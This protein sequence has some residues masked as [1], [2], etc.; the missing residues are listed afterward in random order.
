MQLGRCPVC[1]SRISIDALIQDESGRHLLA[2]LAKLDTTS[3]ATLI[4]YLGLFR[5]ASRDLSND[6][7]LRL[8]QD[9]Q[10]MPENKTH[11]NMAM[12]ETVN[13]MRVKQDQK[14][15]KPL[16]NH[17][18]FKALLKD[19]KN[20]PGQHQITVPKAQATPV[21]VKQETRTK[22]S[23]EQATECLNNIRTKLKQTEK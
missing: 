12:A 6:R 14:C 18:Y 23:K 8:A 13:A 5:S 11:K 10:E 15:F 2:L 1:H 19:I 16:K 22:I 7:A 17:G 21:A 3:A 9:I 20:K 4:N